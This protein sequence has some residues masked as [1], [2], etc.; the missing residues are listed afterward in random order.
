MQLHYDEDL[1]TRDGHGVAA[2][3]IH[4]VGDAR[5]VFRIEFASWTNGVMFAFG[6]WQA[7][8]GSGLVFQPHSEPFHLSHLI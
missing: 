2:L 8:R 4:D 3:G 5:D 7:D 6:S 1:N